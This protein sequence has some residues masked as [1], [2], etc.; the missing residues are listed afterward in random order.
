MCMCFHIYVF[1]TYS[2]SPFTKRPLNKPKATLLINGV[3]GK[4]TQ[5][6][7]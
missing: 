5:V 7:V 3:S 6:K 1:S 2:T 4:Q